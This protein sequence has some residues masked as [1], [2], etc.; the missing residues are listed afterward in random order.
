MK[1]KEGGREGGKGGKDRTSERKVKLFGGEKT[2][3][4]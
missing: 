3:T 4:G 2:H 1:E